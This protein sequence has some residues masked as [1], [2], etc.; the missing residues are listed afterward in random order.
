MRIPSDVA[1]LAADHCITVTQAPYAAT[2]TDPTSYYI[3]QSQA[4]RSVLLLGEWTPANALRVRMS[5]LELA[6]YLS[7][8]TK[9]G[10]PMAPLSADLV[11]SAD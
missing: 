9:K 6:R 8:G 11:A 4:Q 1:A 2:A 7:A 10:A 3:E 5:V